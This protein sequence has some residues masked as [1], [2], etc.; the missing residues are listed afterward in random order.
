MNRFDLNGNE[1]TSIV[2]DAFTGVGGIGDVT[3]AFPE[4]L[5]GAG[6]WVDWAEVAG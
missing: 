5:T 4:E 3:M 1:S 6:P 2:P